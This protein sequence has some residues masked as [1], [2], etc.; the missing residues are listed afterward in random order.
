[1]Q[2]RIAPEEQLTTRKADAPNN[3]ATTKERILEVAERLFVTD[4]FSEASLRRITKEAG[5][6][7][8]A[9][10][11]HFGSKEGLFEAVV[12]RQ[13]GPL[14]LRRVTLLKE[15]ESTPRPG[16]VGYVLQI[17]ESWL[18]PLLDHL[19][20]NPQHVNT[21][22]AIDRVLTARPEVPSLL[23]AA[24]PY[25]MYLARVPQVLHIALPHISLSTM[26]WRFHFMIGAVTHVLSAGDSVNATTGGHCDPSD[27]RKVRAQLLAASLLMLGMT[28]EDA[29]AAAKAKPLAKSRP[30]SGAMTARRRTA[31][32]ARNLR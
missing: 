5:A 32:P 7:L 23:R 6:S 17:L 19:S 21:V 2:V 24:S 20:R 11:Y 29:A 3:S 30:P 25:H 12:E 9:V 31:D 13:F 4:G 1:L 15:L 18:D 8:G 16:D 26:Y 14:L 27:Y 10:N 28:E 22:Y